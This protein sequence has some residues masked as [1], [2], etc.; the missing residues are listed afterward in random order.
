MKLNQS[1]N[2]VTTPFGDVHIDVDN[3]FDQVFGNRSSEH[4]SS[5]HC[6]PGNR[7]WAPR[8]CITESETSY[9]L[10]AELPGVNP[11]DVLLE[12]K[13][14]HLEIS[15]SKTR[16]EVA[17]GF[18]SVRDERLAGSF[19]RSFEFTQQVDADK[20]N[21]EFKNGVLHVTLPK[22]DNVLPRKIQI[23]VIE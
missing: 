5:E 7:G 11:S 10:L 13:E 20:I 9:S 6:Q 3:L 14:G 12:M 23:K 21:A 15:G 18:K 22:A 2:R 8:V 17:E 19:H 4:R 16:A 1:K